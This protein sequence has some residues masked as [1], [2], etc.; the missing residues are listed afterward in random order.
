MATR[1]ERGT[2]SCPQHSV[3]QHSVSQHSVTHLENSRGFA[4]ILSYIDWR[5]NNVGK[6]TVTSL[7]G[8]TWYE[9]VVKGG[10]RGGE[11]RGVEGWE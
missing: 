8:Q 4:L 2:C 9:E 3:S 1:E 10:E 6:L 5:R 7:L 11:G